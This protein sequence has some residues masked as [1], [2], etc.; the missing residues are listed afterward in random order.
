MEA[1]TKNQA[2]LVH[3][4]DSC[5]VPF[6]NTVPQGTGRAREASQ[7]VVSY[8]ETFEASGEPAITVSNP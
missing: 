5:T 3:G 7:G 2:D 8:D 4:L 1:L 6:K